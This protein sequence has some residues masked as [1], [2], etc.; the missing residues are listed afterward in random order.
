M[1]QEYT[2]IEGKAIVKTDNG[3]KEPIEYYDNLNE[4]LVQENLIETME[5]NILSLEKESEKYK[6]IN[7]KPY[8]PIYLLTMLLTALVV[9]PALYCLLINPN[10]YVSSVNSIF[11][12]INNAALVGLTSSFALLPFGL[13]IELGIYRNHKNLLKK[14]KGINSEL[15]FLKKQVIVEKEKLNT[16]KKG[17][18][19]DKNNEKIRV[20]EVSDLELLKRLKKLLDLYFDLGYNEDAY[21]KYYQ[22]NT[23]DANLSQD[24]NGAEIEIAKKYLEEK[25]PTLTKKRKK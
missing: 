25:G 6:K 7:K 15:E 17:K 16:L 19:I 21:Y 18:N 9:F 23:L 20:V 8:I 3:V 12:T 1:N 10:L 14:E 22:N 11:G 2:Y 13:F 24:Y 5:N 4:A